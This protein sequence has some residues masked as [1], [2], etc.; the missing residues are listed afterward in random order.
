MTPWLLEEASQPTEGLYV[1]AFFSEES[2]K[3]VGDWIA[4]HQIPNPVAPSS[5]HVTIVYSRVPVPDFEEN[6]HVEI[7]VDNTYSTLEVWNT[8]SGKTLVLRL[9]CPYLELRF[10]EAM[11]A[12]ATYD[13]EEYNPHITLSYDIGDFDISALPKFNSPLV[14][15]GEYMEIIDFSER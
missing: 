3:V 1:A 5:L 14:I 4:K 7:T 10:R 8:P 12:G 13:F 9:D 2:T 11:M 15:E 6:S